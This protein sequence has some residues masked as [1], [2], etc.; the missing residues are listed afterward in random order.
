MNTFNK[1][2]VLAVVAAAMT[3][4]AYP[5][6]RDI[7]LLQ[8][9]MIELKNSILQLQTTF[10]QKN[11]ATLSL[12]EKIFDQVN[13]LAG[14]MQ[15]VSQA[16]EAVNTHT[17]KSAADL[18]TQMNGFGT[19]INELSDTVAALR[20]QLSGVSQ[21]I[22]TM[23]TT[24]EPLPNAEES[25]RTANFDIQIG[26]YE[27]ALQELAEFQV[28]YPTDPRTAKA[29]IAKGD[30]LMGMKK[31]DQA[32][33]EFDTYLQ[34]YPGSEEISL[35]LY[36]KGLAQIE[37]DPKAA[38]ATFQSLITKYPSSA[39]A[40]L[41]KQKIQQIGARGRRGPDRHNN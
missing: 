39:E 30:A 7:I 12:V 18:K 9:D 21:Q 1:L 22:T 36:K 38:T 2:L 14:N 25:W 28:K 6:N 15:K 23:K 20:S 27:L 3:G 35:A 37:I 41:A 17:D 19:R 40:T 34:K 29:Q 16:V 10:D 32:I 11:S 31:F 4:P 5:Q 8:K 13:G 33:I 26:N 24:A